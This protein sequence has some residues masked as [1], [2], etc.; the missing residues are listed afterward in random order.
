MQELFTA[1]RKAPRPEKI[2]YNLLI[3]LYIYRL[4]ADIPE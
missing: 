4:I 1:I 2:V 3:L